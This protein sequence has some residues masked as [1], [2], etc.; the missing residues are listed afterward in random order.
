MTSS[1]PSPFSPVTYRALG[2]EDAE[3]VLGLIGK[4][5][6]RFSAGGLARLPRNELS[7][8]QFISNTDDVIVGAFQ[9]N[10]CIGIAGVTRMR[11]G[12]MPKPGAGV[13][14]GVDS[15][16]GGRGVATALAIEALKHFKQIFPDTDD[17][18]IHCQPKN[19]KSIK[20]A[21]RLGFVRNPQS[22]YKRHQSS[23]SS[24]KL[25]G[26]AT[27]VSTVLAKDL[28]LEFA[29]STKKKKIEKIIKA[30]EKSEPKRISP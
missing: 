2:V 30:A 21:A 12:A 10:L 18:I 23:R 26:Y 22:D 6:D 28:D 1:N 19:K 27:T 17:A 24:T 20:L 8:S 9:N 4:N 5:S 25:E 13:W 29:A 11:V 15:D 7:Y 3:P 16:A 14:Y